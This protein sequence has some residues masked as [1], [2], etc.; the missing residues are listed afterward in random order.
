MHEMG[1]VGSFELM[2]MDVMHPSRHTINGNQY[3]LEISFMH[4]ANGGES[5]YVSNAALSMLFSVQKNDAYELST[6]CKRNAFSLLDW[7]ENDLVTTDN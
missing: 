7:I 6:K 5:D 2:Y 3:D 4:R 1:A